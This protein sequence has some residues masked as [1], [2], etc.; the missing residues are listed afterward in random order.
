MDLTVGYARISQEEQSRTSLEDQPIEITDYCQRNNL[1]LAH[2]FVENG[3][4]AFTFNRPE[5]L[6]LEAYIKQNKAVKYLVVKHIDRFSRAD[7]V[8]AL[9]KI[10]EIEE[11]LKVKILTVKDTLT[12]DRSEL[13]FK[14]LR[15]MELLMSNNERNRIQERTKDGTYRT[16]TQGRW[17]SLAP[18]GYKNARDDN[19]KPIL[20]VDEMKADKV[21]QVF[22]MFSQGINAFEIARKLDINTSNR[23]FVTEMLQ[24]SIYAGI[25]QVPAYKNKPAYETTSINEPL[26]TKTLFYQVQSMLNRKGNK[27]HG[28]EDVWLRGVLRCHECGKLMTAGKSKGTGGEYWYYKCGTHRKNYAAKKL[29]EQFLKILDECSLPI[30]SLAAIKQSLITKIDEMRTNRGGDF[31]RLKM[32]LAKLKKK[33]TDVQER[34]LA[35]GDIDASIY[36]KTMHD[37]KAKEVGIEQQINDLHDTDID[38]YGKIDE[39]MV[40]LN[41]LRDTFEKLPVHLK[42]R[43][44]LVQLTANLSF[45]GQLFYA[46]KVHPLFA[47]NV[48]RLNALGLIEI[49]NLSEKIEEVCGGTPDLT[50]GQIY[51]FFFLT[52]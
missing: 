21:R 5:W 40:V 15:T 10:R 12:Q 22:T 50:I 9:I 23:S 7:L 3:K 14:I 25:I 18:Y 4:S 28:N 2:I 39:L 44:I 52:G 38:L 19:N 20:L 46:D 29:H 1:N 48:D 31:M 37:F 11:K 34:Y 42:Q 33:I 51:D 26:I 45:S 24:K 27:Y 16:L 36:Q 49:K 43:F 35:T 41:N 32:E 6:K 47:H 8:D 17:S 13:G 30:E